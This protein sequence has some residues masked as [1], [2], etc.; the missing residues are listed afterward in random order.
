MTQIY[1]DQTHRYKAQ[2]QIARDAENVIWRDNCRKRILFPYGYD[3][4][5]MNTTKWIECCGDYYNILQLIVVHAACMA[6][7]FVV[8]AL[9]MYVV[10]SNTTKIIV[11]LHSQELRFVLTH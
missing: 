6:L 1:Y 2:L 5:G 10:F 11:S 3:T 7:C 9:P 4:I 8:A